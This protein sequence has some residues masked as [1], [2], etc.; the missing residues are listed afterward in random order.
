MN[1]Q[2]KQI[3]ADGIK[4]MLSKK[5]AK[6]EQSKYIFE[7]LQKAGDT[8]LEAFMFCLAYMFGRQGLKNENN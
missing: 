1:D 4:L 3:V 7:E 6:M 5:H 2:D 8:S